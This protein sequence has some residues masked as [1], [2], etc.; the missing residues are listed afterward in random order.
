MEYNNALWEQ[1][2]K[3]K[4]METNTQ[5]QILPL[6]QKKLNNYAYYV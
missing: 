4:I 1:A 3:K 6:S 2:G 5:L